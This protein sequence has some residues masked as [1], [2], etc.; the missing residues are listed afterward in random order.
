MPS[1]GGSLPTRCEKTVMR[2]RKL[3]A[4]QMPLNAVDAPGSS[5][6]LTDIRMGEVNGLTVLQEFKQLSPDTSVV[7]LT[8]FGSLDGAIEGIKLGAYDYSISREAV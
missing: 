2:S 1:L 4:V 7:L 8:A 5:R 6:V 3:P